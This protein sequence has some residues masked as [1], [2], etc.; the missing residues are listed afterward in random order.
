MFTRSFSGGNKTLP[1]TVKN[2]GF[3][4]DR[5]GQDCHP[6]QFLRELTRNAIEAIQR[7]E[8]PG[9]ILWD[10]DWTTYDLAGVLK[11]SVVDTGDGMTG[12]EMVEHINKLSSSASEQSLTGNYGVG[13]KIAAA[14]KN[15]EG[16]LYL[17][18]KDS[19]GSM[20]HLWRN[21]EDGVYG[22]KQLAKADG[23]YSEYLEL[24]D[25]V[26]PE[27]IANHGTM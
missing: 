23:S 18:W 16:M 9:Q 24:E 4:L 27:H 1:M 17:S 8:K 6:L 21:P 26:K 7:T 13:A 15:H 3:L 10:V 20:I 14:T 11:L 25:A 22:L 12:P 5:L 2:T 19:R